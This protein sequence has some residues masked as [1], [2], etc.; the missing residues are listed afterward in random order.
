MDKKGLF[1]IMLNLMRGGL[2]LSLVIAVVEMALRGPQERLRKKGFLGILFAALLA[3]L[4]PYM[5]KIIYRTLARPQ[6]A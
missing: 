4:I 5:A 2:S 6:K 1:N 3:F